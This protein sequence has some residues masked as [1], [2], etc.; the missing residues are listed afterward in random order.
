MRRL[1]LIFVAAFSAATLLSGMGGAS[2]AE[3]VPRITVE[4]LRAE[5]GSP[6]LVVLDVRS[7]RDWRRS[8]RKITGAIREDSSRAQTW[9][10]KYGKE[11]K[12]VLYCT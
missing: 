5:L 10:G 1:I 3:K 8:D 2:S 4:E 6:D 7:D 11:K 9:A 12:L